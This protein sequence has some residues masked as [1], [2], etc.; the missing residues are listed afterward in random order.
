MSQRMIK[1]RP[2]PRFR[3]LAASVVVLS[4]AV[5]IF[6]AWSR[7]YFWVWPIVAL[8]TVAAIVFLSAGKSLSVSSRSLR[9]GF[10]NLPENQIRDLSSLPDGSAVF[11]TTDNRCYRIDRRWYHPD[12]WPIVLGNIGGGHR[13][14]EHQSAALY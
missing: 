5:F 12:D 1:I 4:F 14:V 8:P 6:T 3:I 11:V 13:S 10:T 9:L 7:S 2:N